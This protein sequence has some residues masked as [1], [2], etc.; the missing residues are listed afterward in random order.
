MTRVF[1]K[2]LSRRELLKSS[3]AAAGVSF[4]G[5]REAGWPEPVR[6]REIDSFRHGKRLGIVSFSEEEQFP[7][8]KLFGAELDARLFTD[9]SALDPENPREPTPT[10]TFYIRTG[11]SQLLD[12]QA[13]WAVR[14]SGLVERPFDLSPR[15]LEKAA[16]PMG[17]HL[18]ECAGNA[19][20]VH[21]GMMSIADW[22]GVTLTE[23]LANAK[24]KPESSHVLISGFDR[25][26]T[27][28]VTSQPGAS[29][30]FTA[31]ELKS[32]RAFLATQMNG[33]PLT[34]DH[35]A[36]I[37]L[38][39]PGWYG[40]AC[41]KW[42]NEIV[43]VDDFADATSQMQEYASRTMQSGVPQLA[44][45][46]RSAVVEQAAMPIRVEKWSAEGRIKYRIIG[47][48][49]GGSCLVKS[50]GIRFN[51]E[52]NYVPVDSFRQTANEP[53]SF[54]EHTWTPKQPGRYLIRLRVM[55]PTV[56]AR[57]LEA[58]Y[59]VR[60]VDITETLGS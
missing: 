36:P 22:Q 29:W 40:C 8:G 34:R 59:Y 21:F 32:A 43:L 48:L 16:E 2:N 1:R 20:R 27:P 45:D 42:V 38:V 6:N 9:L 33:Q 60:S 14:V 35:G 50:L 31:E 18:L 55:E 11:A 23:I 5:F 51:P 46:Y 54:W 39:V 25:Y 58:G 24:A 12:S 19:R 47:I 4:A 13:S 56:V 30:I 49:W 26:Q 15:E 17:L 37:R 7:M 53:W 10:D 41:I 57:R 52:E 3:L 44:R 28:S